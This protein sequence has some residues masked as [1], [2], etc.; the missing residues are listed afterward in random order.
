MLLMFEKGVQG[1]ITQTVNAMSRPTMTISQTNATLRRHI[2]SAKLSMHG[3]A[4]KKVDDFT[5]KKIDQLV[6]RGKGKF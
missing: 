6:K 2:Y 1:G 4:R 3:F 5:P